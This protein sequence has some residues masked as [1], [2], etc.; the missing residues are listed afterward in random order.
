[1]SFMKKVPLFPGYFGEHGLF[2]ISNY[3]YDG[4]PSCLTIISEEELLSVKNTLGD[5]RDGS[6]ISKSSHRIKT[7]SGGINH[8]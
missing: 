8:G 7:E 1:M 3:M 6:Y 4:R 2:I 5:S